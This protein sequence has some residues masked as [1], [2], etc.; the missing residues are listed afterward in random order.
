M[1]VVAPIA[2]VAVKVWLNAAFTVPLFVAGLLTVMTWQ[3]MVSV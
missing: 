3:A 2:F 1:K